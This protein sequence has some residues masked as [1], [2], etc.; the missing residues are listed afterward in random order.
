MRRTTIVVAAE[1]AVVVTVVTTIART[2][3]LSAFFGE[4]EEN[5]KFGE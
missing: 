1:V 3:K 4:Q 5:D 2:V